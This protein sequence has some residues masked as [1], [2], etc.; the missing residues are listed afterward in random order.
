MILPPSLHVRGTRAPLLSAFYLILLLH[1]GSVAATAASL[2][3]AGAAFS[4]G[5]TVQANVPL[6]A[7]EKSLAAQG[8]NVV[9]PT[10][11]AVLATP[12]NFDPRKSWPA[13]VIRSTTDF[14]RQTRHDLL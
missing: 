7:Q 1:A 2:T 8:G 13:L 12:A 5:S 6:S 11:L 10:A 3:F 4:P 14:N 9:P